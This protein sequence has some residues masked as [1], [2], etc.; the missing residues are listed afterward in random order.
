MELFVRDMLPQMVNKEILGT[1][2]PIVNT[3]INILK[4]A[5]KSRNSMVILSYSPR[6]SFILH[7]TYNNFH[8]LKNNLILDIG[9]TNFINGIVTSFVNDIQTKIE[10]LMV[11]LRVCKITTKIMIKLQ[12]YLF[13]F[14][15][16]T[17]EIT[18]RD[19]C[20]EFNE[21]TYFNICLS[22]LVEYKRGFEILINNP[23]F[24]HYE[25]KD[26]LY[27]Y[28]KSVFG[29]KN[30]RSGVVPDNI[31]C[32]ENNFGKLEIKDE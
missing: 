31:L 13:D 19:I 22:D 20:K 8:E 17:S 23:I 2:Q 9:Y 5:I 18:F 4:E 3:Y 12:D 29:E 7:N 6:T 15:R 27:G 16:L 25:N 32:F 30:S 14:Y 26:V 21:M 24:E 1:I 10:P 28:I 11:Y